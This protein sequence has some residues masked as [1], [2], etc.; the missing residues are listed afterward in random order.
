MFVTSDTL[1]D[2]YFRG[3]ELTEITGRASRLATF[4][5]SV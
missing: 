3:R 5:D 2:T 1:I 4:P